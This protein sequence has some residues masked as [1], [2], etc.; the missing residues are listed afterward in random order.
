MPLDENDRDF[1]RLCA[2]LGLDDDGS[3]TFATVDSA[4][5]SF[6][7][8]RERQEREAS[9]G[10]R[11]LPVP[12]PAPGKFKVVWSAEMYVYGEGRAELLRAS[13]PRCYVTFSGHEGQ[14][15]VLDLDGTTLMKYVVFDDY[16]VTLTV[17]G[18]QIQGR[19]TPE[20]E[21]GFLNLTP[22]GVLA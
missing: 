10:R 3:V 8:F 5:R 4:A 15:Y 11:V 12:G 14:A 1:R 16:A 19:S 6:R 20:D 2:S 21:Y 13:W 9:E 17:T 22:V 18:C 7:F